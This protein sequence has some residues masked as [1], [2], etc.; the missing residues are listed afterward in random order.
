MHS[1]WY[2]S[3]RISKWVIPQ[4]YYVSFPHS[5]HDIYQLRA[6]RLAISHTRKNYFLTHEGK[7]IKDGLPISFSMRGKDFINC[8]RRINELT[9]R[10]YEPPKEGETY[11]DM[12]K[13][14]LEERWSARWFDLETIFEKVSEEEAAYN[15][16]EW[17][18][19]LTTWEGYRTYLGSRNA[20][21]RPEDHLTKPHQLNRLCQEEEE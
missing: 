13:L 5:I 21:V 2:I 15:E 14:P 12:M 7:T 19:D 11:E 10:T 3:Y 8:R 17:Y 6:D 20:I 16:V 18:H 4:K 9:T 1:A